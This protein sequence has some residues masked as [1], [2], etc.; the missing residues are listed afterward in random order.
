MEVPRSDFDTELTHARN[1]YESL[2]GNSI[3]TDQ[4]GKQLLANIKAQIAQRLITEAIQLNEIKKANFSIDDATVEHA[5]QAYLNEQ[6]LTQE[7]FATALERNGYSVDYFMR[8]FRDRVL[9]ESYLEQKI[10]TGLTTA[11]QKQKRYAEWFANARL[12]AEIDYYDKD[13]E[14]QVALNSRKGGCGN[15]CSASK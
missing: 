6:G 9:I 14:R 13:L 2:Y 4:R 3:F 7:A 11:N 10:F 8:K 15:S 1:R 5:Y 12:L